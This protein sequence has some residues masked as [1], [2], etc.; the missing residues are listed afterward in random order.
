VSKEDTKFSEYDAR[1]ASGP[2]CPLCGRVMATGQYAGRKAWTCLIEE[3]LNARMPIQQGV[4]MLER[5]KAQASKAEKARADKVAE[6][7]DPD[8]DI[9]GDILSDRLALNTR[10]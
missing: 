3:H 6:S 10:N 4:D 9:L 2:P 8:L 7:I 1:N 5:L